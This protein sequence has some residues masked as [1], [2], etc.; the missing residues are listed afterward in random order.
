VLSEHCS[1]YFSPM[2]FLLLI[3]CREGLAACSAFLF[4]SRRV[5]L[6]L[7]EPFSY[8]WSGSL[9]A[10]KLFALLRLLLHFLFIA[11]SW[12]WP[13]KADDLSDNG[14]S[15]IS[16]LVVS[17]FWLSTNYHSVSGIKVLS[18]NNRSIK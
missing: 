15:E 7:L 13:A 6:A 3:R 5:N 12:Q 8:A 4:F 18:H 16:H 10:Q 2:C 11:F 1:R 17:G 14:L 9:P